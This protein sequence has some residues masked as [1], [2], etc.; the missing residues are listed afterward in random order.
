MRHKGESYNEIVKKLGV[1]KGTLS[2]WFKGSK[3][4][5]RIKSKNISQAKLVWARN[6]SLFNKRRSGEARANWMKLQVDASKLVHWL[7][8]ND[9][10]LVGTSL[11]W[12][13]G[14][15]KGNWS[16]VFSNSD[17]QMHQLMIRFFREICGVPVNKLRG[18]V[19]I[20]QNI[21]PREAV[22]YWSR[23]TS[24]PAK[25]F[26]KCN[27]SISISSKKRRGNTLPYGTLRVRINDVRLVNKIKGLIKGLIK[28]TGIGV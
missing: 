19:Q 4:S 6:I 13:E 12:A 7:S 2:Y 11:Y 21:K 23:V 18:Q 17:P 26:I 20:Y 25:Q 24:I 9:L 27:K 10:L 15:K 14:Y 16:V 28:S 22:R 1:S 3:E 8:R 5:Q